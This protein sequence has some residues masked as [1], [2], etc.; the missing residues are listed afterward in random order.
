MQDKWTPADW[1]AERG[2]DGCLRLLIEAGADVN[3][4][5]RVDGHVS[6]LATAAQQVRELPLSAH[7]MPSAHPFSS[8]QRWAYGPC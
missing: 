5:D 1:A 6:K 4:L 2:H 8:L 3:N 7:A